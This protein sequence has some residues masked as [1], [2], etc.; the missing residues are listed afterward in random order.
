MCWAHPGMTSEWLPWRR[1]THFSKKIKS[2]QRYLEIFI[3]RCCY[4][5]LVQ[6][7]SRFL[8]SFHFVKQ[9]SGS[10]VK[11]V[12]P[13]IALQ[14]RNIFLFVAAAGNAAKFLEL[15]APMR[16]YQAAWWHAPGM[17]AVDVTSD[18][19]SVFN[20]VFINTQLIL[21]QNKLNNF[22]RQCCY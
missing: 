6:F 8:V 14:I 4:L 18:R 12:S 3:I 22:S 17:K 1:E 20:L 19:A 16:A 13:E 2:S 9:S 10:E 11:A 7:P 5:M 15:R 21:P